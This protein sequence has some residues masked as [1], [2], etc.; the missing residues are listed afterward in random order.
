MLRLLARPSQRLLCQKPLASPL[1]GY[2]GGSL[3]GVEFADAVARVIHILQTHEKC[4]DGKKVVTPT[5]HFKQDLGLDS[6]DVVEI[7]FIIEEE[8]KIDLLEHE[9]E[10]LDSVQA[11]ADF[12][13][14]H[15]LAS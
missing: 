14:K 13:H 5:S 7:C 15:P 11:V 1:R 8:F 6:L 4:A 3:A 2:S 12:I 10:A 9:A